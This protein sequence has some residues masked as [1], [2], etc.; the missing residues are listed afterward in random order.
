MKPFKSII[1][2][3]RVDYIVCNINLDVEGWKRHKSVKRLFSTC[4]WFVQI[5]D[6]FWFLVQP[7]T[8]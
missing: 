5:S 3:L 1:R 4:F 6:Q 7:F 2:F 8:G